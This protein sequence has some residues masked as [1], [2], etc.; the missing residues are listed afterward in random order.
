MLSKC[1]PENDA[2]EIVFPE[3]MEFCSWNLSFPRRI[4][5]VEMRLMHLVTGNKKATTELQNYKT[6]TS[7]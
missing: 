1:E 7:I 3:S 4:F 6:I 2:R 5:V